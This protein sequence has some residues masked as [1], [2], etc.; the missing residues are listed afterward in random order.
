MSLLFSSPVFNRAGAGPKQAARCLPV[1]LGDSLASALWKPGCH[2]LPVGFG[3]VLSVTATGGAS[4]VTVL[5]PIIIAQSVTY[6]VTGNHRFL[7][8]SSG[9]QSPE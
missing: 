5:L 8:F 6:L 2:W 3:L 9:R 1:L 7:A 4:S